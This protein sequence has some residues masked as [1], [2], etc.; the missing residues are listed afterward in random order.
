MHTRASTGA[1]VSVV[2]QGDKLVA[3]LRFGDEWFDLN[4]G[5]GRPFVEA[6]KEL[7]LLD[8]NGVVD[9]Q[10]WTKEG[11]IGQVVRMPDGT[12]NCYA[13]EG[14]N[15]EFSW[16]VATDQEREIIF[17]GR[18][19]VSKIEP[20]DTVVA[21]HHDASCGNSGWQEADY[22]ERTADGHRVCLTFWPGTPRTETVVQHVRP[23]DDAR[24][25]GMVFSA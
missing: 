16:R 17:A 11:P 8:K 3:R 5:A 10:H 6:H 14:T 4:E 15:D 7:I 21:F 25:D 2:E 1:T 12:L 13:R 24:R 19:A 20:G 9:Y 22:R 23:I 18:E